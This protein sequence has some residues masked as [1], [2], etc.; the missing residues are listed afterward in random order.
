MRWRQTSWLLSSVKG[1][2]TE[3][4]TTFIASVVFLFYEISEVYIYRKELIYEQK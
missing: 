4:K 3:I 1:I 2:P